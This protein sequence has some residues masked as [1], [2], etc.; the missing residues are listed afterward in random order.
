MAEL[1][2]RSAESFVVMVDLRFR[3]VSLNPSTCTRV[4]LGDPIDLLRTAVVLIT[5]YTQGYG[6]RVEGL[7][8][9]LAQ[10]RTRESSERARQKVSETCQQQVYFSRLVAGGKCFIQLLHGLLEL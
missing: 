5:S 2:K 6:V 4:V 7:H 9:M 8:H 1:R 10:A 3:L